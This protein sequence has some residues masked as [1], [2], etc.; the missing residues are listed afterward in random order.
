M[1]FLKI[2]YGIGNETL[3]CDSKAMCQ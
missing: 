1:I 2:A 3:T